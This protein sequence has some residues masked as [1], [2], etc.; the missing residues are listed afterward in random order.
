MRLL[1]SH[2]QAD[3]LVKQAKDAA[4]REICGL[5]AGKDGRVSLILP[6]ANIADAPTRAYRMDEHALAHAL[7][8]LEYQTVGL[9]AIYHSHPTHDPIPSQM[10][11]RQWQYPDTAM[12]IISLKDEPRVTAWQIRSTGSQPLSIHIGNEPPPPRYPSFSNAQKAAI[13]VS[14]V[15]AAILVLIIAVTLLPPAPAIPPTP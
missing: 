6:I 8:A 3:E 7:F 14:A 10:D 5:L 13:I 15:A 12:M 2:Q 11:I 4:P 9:L 1:L